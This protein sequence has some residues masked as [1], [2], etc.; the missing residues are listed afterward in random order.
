MEPIP[1]TEEAG[2][3][4]G[5]LHDLGR[6]A[7]SIVPEL[8]GLS[9]GLVRDGLTFTLVASDAAAAGIDA[10][11]YLDG[12]PCL[13]GDGEDATI[14]VDIDDLMHD[15]TWELF[16]HASRAS[17]V[18]SSLSLP[19]FSRGNLIGGINLYAASVGAFAG[20][21]AELAAALGASAEGALSDTDLTFSSRDRTEDTPRRL[22]E[23]YD[24]DVAAGI[25]AARNRETVARATERLSA[26]AGRAGL[27]PAVVARVL[28]DLHTGP[29]S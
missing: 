24:V 20:H 14:Q 4:E 2:E 10:A 5:R 28:L 19:V 22:R 21:Q 6:V 23:Q 12:G 18:A 25:L 15:D 1:Q 27:T 13:R 8:V 16:A 29:D 11:Q 17:G 7:R 3:L 9:L 26:A